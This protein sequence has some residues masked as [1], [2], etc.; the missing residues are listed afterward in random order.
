MTETLK[1]WEF[2]A[3]CGEFYILPQ[4][5]IENEELAKLIR[6]DAPIEVIRNFLE[7]EF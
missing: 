4:L 2:Y 7:N 6:E 3:L 1:A 5:A